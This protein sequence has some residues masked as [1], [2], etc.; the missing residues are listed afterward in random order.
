MTTDNIIIFAILGVALVLFVS[1]KLRVDL[2]ALMVLVTLTLTG[3]I[4]PQDAFSGFSSP[5]VITVWAVFIISGGLTRSGVA[6]VIARVILRLAGHNQI[7]LIILIMLT[8]G[9]MSAFMNNIGA[10]AILLPAVV[11]VARE[12]KT[13]PSKLLIPLAW[14]SLMGG[15][16]T[17][18]GTP[19]NI[20]ASSILESYE[21]IPNFTFLDFVPMGL[22]VLTTGILYMV[23]IGRH[24]LPDRTSDTGPT[25]D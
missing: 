23:L 4:S 17:L 22:I 21:N 15:N 5:A 9:V 1:E 11:S 3:L 12:M 7:R 13:S 16:I 18:I 25:E 19:P 2:V 20:L 6:D 10:V 24:L 8:V 14:G